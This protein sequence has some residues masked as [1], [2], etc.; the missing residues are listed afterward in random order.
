MHQHDTSK[1]APHVFIDSF[2]SELVIKYFIF[3]I[4]HIYVPFKIISLYVAGVQGTVCRRYS[5]A[6]LKYCD[7]GQTLVPQGL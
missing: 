4:F 7:T 6:S 2:I 3:S 1:Q 5:A